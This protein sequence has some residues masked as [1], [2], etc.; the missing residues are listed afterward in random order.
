MDSVHLQVADVIEQATQRHLWIAHIISVLRCSDH[1]HT[2]NKVDSAVL[3]HLPARD[4][5]VAEADLVKDVS[6]ELSIQKFVRPIFSLL[7]SASAL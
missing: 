4:S 7:C 3:A 1:A 2:G 6:L 5:Q